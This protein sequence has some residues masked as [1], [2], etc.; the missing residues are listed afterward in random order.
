MRPKPPGDALGFPPGL[1]P[2]PFPCAGNATGTGEGEGIAASLPPGGD[3]PYNMT[4][5]REQASSALVDALAAAA[6]DPRF[7][8]QLANCSAAALG[9]LP[10]VVLQTFMLYVSDKG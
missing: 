5:L 9:A 4:A 10:R 2:S 1:S 7:A 6:A 8:A 3:G